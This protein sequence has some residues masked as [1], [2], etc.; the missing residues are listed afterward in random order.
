MR[1]QFN[2]HN[3]AQTR[4][5]THKKRAQSSGFENE[6]CCNNYIIILDFQTK[7]D[8]YLAGEMF[9]KRLKNTVK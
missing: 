7:E 3:H 1:G 8:L 4:T 9:S 2:P 5:I 6:Q